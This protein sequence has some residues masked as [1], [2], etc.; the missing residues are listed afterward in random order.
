MNQP[1]PQGADRNVATLFF[2]SEAHLLMVVEPNGAEEKALEL[3]KANP[4]RARFMYGA[5]KA[6]PKVDIES[7]ATDPEI[8]VD[9]LAKAFGEPPVGVWFERRARCEDLPRKQSRHHLL[10]P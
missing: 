7:P 4:L 1:F 3:R 8:G 2:G 9:Q 5:R 6:Q 10:K